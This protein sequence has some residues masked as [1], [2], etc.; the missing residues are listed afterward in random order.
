MPDYPINYDVS[1]QK[2][3]VDRDIAATKISADIAEKQLGYKWQ[4]LKAKAEAKIKRNYPVPDFGGDPDILTT[5]KNMKDAEDKLGKW[6]PELS[7]VEEDLRMEVPIFE[8]LQR[9]NHKYNSFAQSRDDQICTSV[10]CPKNAFEKEEE[11]KIV[12][13]PTNVPLDTEMNQNIKS[14]RY[15]TEYHNEKSDYNGRT[16]A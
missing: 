15:A 2:L 4:N 6:T 14:E 16:L 7:Q 11:E 1:Y 3:G 9:I 8:A 12:Q 13:Y 5:K 10:G